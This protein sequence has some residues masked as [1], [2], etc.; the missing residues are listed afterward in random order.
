MLHIHRYK[1]RLCSKNQR[2]SEDFPSRQHTIFTLQHFACG[3]VVDAWPPWEE[4]YEMPYRDGMERRQ[5]EWSIQADA[6]LGTGLS[7]PDVYNWNTVTQDLIGEHKPE[8]VIV[9]NLLETTVRHFVTPKV[10]NRF[11]FPSLNGRSNTSKRFW[12]ILTYKYKL[13]DVVM[14]GM[15]MVDSVRFQKRL[16]IANQQVKEAAE[17]KGVL[18]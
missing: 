13:I 17:E 11:P 7:R 8:M 16:K 9:N 10:P 12:I 1:Q 4:T 2:T 5:I 14:I 18:Y 15:P 3:C 6:K